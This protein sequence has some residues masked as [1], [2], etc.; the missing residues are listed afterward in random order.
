MNK[1]LTKLLNTIHFLRHHGHHYC[2]VEKL[3]K[4]G[5]IVGKN[6]NIQH[7]VELDGSRPWLI[8]IGD[9]VVIAPNVHILTHD[10]STKALIGLVKI[11]QVVIENNVFIG[12]GSI[13]LPNVVIGENSII[14]AGSV[15]S[16]CVEPFSVYA[17]NPAKL[18]MRID[19]YIEK[20]TNDLPRFDYPEYHKDNITDEQK[21]FMKKELSG[22][23]GYIGK[24]R[25]N[26]RA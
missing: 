4:E 24:K 26:G 13:I 8:E 15:V 2:N 18:I 23:G 22:I 19:D 21:A 17:G 14:G 7:G 20:N 25:T 6:L 9:N 5:L 3:K 11:G 10:T 16:G 12:A 1:I